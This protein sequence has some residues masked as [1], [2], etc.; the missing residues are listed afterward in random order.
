MIDLLHS[1]LINLLFIGAFSVSYSANVQADCIV[2]SQEQKTQHNKPC[3]PNKL[4]Q[5]NRNK[6]AS[7]TAEQ[8][9]EIA[10]KEDDAWIEEFHD[11]VSEGVYQ[12]A[13]WFDNFFI[14]K[15]GQQK[16]PSTIAKIS[17]QWAP[18]ARNLEKMKARF[19][20]KVDLP[21]FSD[22]MDLILSDNDEDTLNQ[23]PLESINTQPQTNSEHF[24]AAVRYVYLQDSNQ[25][26]DTRLGI[27]SGDIFA[28]ARYVRRLTWNKSHSLK[29]EPSVYYFLADGWGSKLLLEYDYK[30][31]DQ[32]QF[33]INYS[34]R[35]SQ[36]YSGVRWKHGF[37][38]LNQ[39]DTTTASLVGLQVEGERNGERGFVVDKYTLSYRY[40]FNAYK[41][42]LY[43]EV[44]PFLEWPEDVNYRTTPGIALKVEGFFYKH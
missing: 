21:H 25:F 12:S 40:R 9:K 37:Y 14:D 28:R 5:K 26:T 1:R 29:V 16:N 18:K 41:E 44:E 7:K 27:S 3:E 24:A 32:S 19:R 39:I 8:A 15:D 13:L 2:L 36:S 31:S 20:I 23:L 22:K 42:W 35:G 30:L 33:R 10:E 4:L 34:T 38:K 17:L 11:T 6:E 43:F